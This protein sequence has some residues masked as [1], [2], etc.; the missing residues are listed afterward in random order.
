MVEVVLVRS[1]EKTLFLPQYSTVC[2]KIKI[3]YRI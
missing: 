3:K 2:K 1:L